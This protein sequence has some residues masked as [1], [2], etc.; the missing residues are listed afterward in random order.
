MVGMLLLIY[1]QLEK[2]GK[3]IKNNLTI[4]MKLLAGYGLKI[5]TLQ[6][7]MP[8]KIKEEYKNNFIDDDNAKNYLFEIEIAWHFYAKGCK[9]EWHDDDSA[10]HSE[11]LVTTPIFDFN[12][13]CKRFNVDLARKIRRR[14]FYRLAEKLVPAIGQKGYFGNIDIKLKDRLHSNDNYLNE[15]TSQITNLVTFEDVQN[16]DFQIPHGSIYF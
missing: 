9:I 6:K 2:Q 11:F 15:L 12:V 8:K 13:E 16:G 4:D 7:Y 10:T 5:S 3:S 14:D 1:L